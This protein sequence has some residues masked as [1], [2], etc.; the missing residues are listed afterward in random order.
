MH[1]RHVLIGITVPVLAV[2]ALAVVTVSV[3]VGAAAPAFAQ[4]NLTSGQ[5][6]YRASADKICQAANVRLVTSA[7]AYELQNEVSRAG[8]R[9]KKTKVAKPGDVIRFVREIASGEMSD[10]I[11]LLKALP[12]PADDKTAMTKLFAD[13]DKALKSLTAKPGEVAY[14]DPFKPVVKQ[15]KSLGFVDCGKNA[16]VA[17]PTASK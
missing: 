5:Q 13:A 16:S 12:V 8:A 2:P 14:A 15:F 3:V 6:S 7:K 10:Q 17:T 1:L 9:S 4:G 11:S